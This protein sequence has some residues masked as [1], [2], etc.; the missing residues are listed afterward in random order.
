MVRIYNPSYA[1]LKEGGL[2][3][4]SGSRQS[5]TLY[6]RQNLKKNGPVGKGEEVFMA[7][8]VQCLPWKCKTLGSNNSTSKKFVLLNSRSSKALLLCSGTCIFSLF[9]AMI[10]FGYEA[11]PQKDLVEVWSLADGAIKMWLKQEGANFV[12]ES[13]VSRWGLV[14]EVHHWGHVFQWYILSPSFLSLC[15]LST[16]RWATLVHHMLPTLIFCLTTVP[17]TSESSDQWLKLW[18]QEPE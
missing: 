8:V 2:C 15:V 7:Q 11:F 12:D 6:E 10:W 4:K 16:T 14:E 13:A 17:E 5:E 9:S 1:E 18:N 3:A